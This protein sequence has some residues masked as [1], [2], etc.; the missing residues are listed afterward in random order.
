MDYTSLIGPAVVAAGVSGLISV[1]QIVVSARTA[2]RM[3]T[4]RLAFDHQKFAADSQLAERKFEIDKELAERK[5]AAD[6]ALAQRKFAL[7]RAFATWKRRS[8]LA[9]QA[10]IRFNEVQKVFLWVRNRGSF[11]SE[12]ESRTPEPGEDERVK[13]K[14]NTYF[15]PIERLNREKELF[16]ALQT[17]RPPFEAHF[18]PEAGIPFKEISDIYNAIIAAASTMMEVAKFPSPPPSPFGGQEVP[19]ASVLNTMGWG[20][21]NRPDDIDRRI[22]AAVEAIRTLCDPVLA[23]KPEA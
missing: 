16:S 2:R 21:Q 7:D 18:G 5:A 1:A 20:P 6:I 17:L 12:G 11:G 23:W 3:H 19:H 9:E 10:L 8:E 22:D 14:R 4:E 15:I 13:Q